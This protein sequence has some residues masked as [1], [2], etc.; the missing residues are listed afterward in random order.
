MERR[1]HAPGTAP[2]PDKT[3]CSAEPPRRKASVG[4]DARLTRGHRT[5]RRPVLRA[6]LPKRSHYPS[7]PDR[8]RPSICTSGCG[9][10]KSRTM[11]EQSQ[12]L[13]RCQPRRGKADVVIA[14]M[15]MTAK[16]VIRVS[17]KNRVEVVPDEP[18]WVSQN[19]VQLEVVGQH[20]QAFVLRPCCQGEMQN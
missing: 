15:K 13:A 6:G 5:A 17:V 3:R 7:P 16:S 1:H 2:T 20:H 11:N 4:A 12:R 19:T 18:N 9:P 8:L 14:G 10:P